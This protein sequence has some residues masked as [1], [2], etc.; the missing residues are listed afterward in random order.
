[1]TLKDQMQALVLVLIDMMSVKA[2]TC[3]SGGKFMWSTIAQD[4]VD[5]ALQVLDINREY[6]RS[7]AIATAT[8]IACNPYK[9]PPAIISGEAYE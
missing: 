6:R 2:V 8:S 7:S 3:V 5:N 9:N 4:F 1:M